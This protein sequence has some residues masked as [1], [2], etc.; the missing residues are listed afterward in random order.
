MR[1]SAFSLR[2]G[3]VSCC[4]VLSFEHS[5]TPGTKRST[6]YQVPVCTCWVIVFLLFLSV[7]LS[8]SPCFCPHANITR[9]ADQNVTRA[10]KHTTQHREISFAQAALGIINSLFARNHGPLL[11]AP[12][13][14]FSCIILCAGVAGSRPRSGALVELLTNI[15]FLGGLY[16]FRF[17][18]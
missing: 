8:R 11:S 16:L 13:T 9:T 12:F 2:C 14:C 6:R 7:D 1:C 10:N 15:D 3:A 17:P 4:A 5:A 18:R